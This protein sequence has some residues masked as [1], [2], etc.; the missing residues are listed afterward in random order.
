M[1]AN[2]YAK[3]RGRTFSRNSTSIEHLKLFPP[4]ALISVFTIKIITA[5]NAD[6]FTK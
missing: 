6:S 2:T 1:T 4:V 5:A 3:I